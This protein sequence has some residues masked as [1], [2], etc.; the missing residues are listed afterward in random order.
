MYKKSHNKNCYLQGV[1]VKPAGETKSSSHND[2]VIRG[3]TVK[4]I[5]DKILEFTSNQDGIIEIYEINTWSKE[6]KLLK[7]FRVCNDIELCDV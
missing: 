2:I 3:K 6:R 5:V 1:W 4:E 7:S